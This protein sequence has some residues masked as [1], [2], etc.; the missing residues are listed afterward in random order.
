MNFNDIVMYV[1]AVGVLLGAL[2]RIFGNRFGLGERFEEGFK[3][4][5][6]VGLNMVG[7]I[8]LAP[9]IANVLGP[10][11]IPVF[12]AVGLDPSMFAMIL[13]NDM[14][15]YS[16]AVEL[17][18]NELLGIYAGTT[19]ASMIGCTIVFAIPVGITL[20]GKENYESFF[21]GVTIGIIAMPFGSILGGL[22]C[23]LSFWLLFKNCIPLILLAALLG[24]G[25]KL[26]PHF[27]V[28]AFSVFGRF[29]TCV[30]TVGLAAAGF[31]TL[32]G[33]CLIP[34]MYELSEG[35]DVLISIGIVLMGSYPI[36]LL[37]QKAV[38]KPLA[39]L[40]TKIGLNTVSMLG[41]LV[42]LVNSVPVFS[43]L[44]DMD[45]RGKIL[46]SAWVVCAAASV[47]AHLGFTA[48]VRP[49]MIG[50]MMIGKLTSGVVAVA[51]AA[52]VTRK[53]KVN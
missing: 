21:K 28:R 43:M 22:S 38:E 11:V 7:I 26:C 48:S 12:K 4:I 51:L 6:P 32:T 8:C 50:P 18:E 9:V 46:N 24:L 14:G 15:G 23:G 42:A 20:C 41:F 33:I 13:A 45:E 3:N 39:K 52:L 31:Q 25:L 30:A 40:G 36:I 27:L 19:I 17:A 10:V 37:V 53:K 47:G 35:T 16:L 2:D 34:G 29:I 5:G 49:D 1:V 44:R